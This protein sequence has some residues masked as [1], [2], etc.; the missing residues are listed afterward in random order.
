MKKNTTA[1]QNEKM[2]SLIQQSDIRNVV[3]SFIFGDPSETIET[4]EKTISWW[5][6]HLEYGQLT[7]QPIMVWPGS[8][9]YDDVC[10]S[11][12]IQPLE[13][14]EKGCPLIN[15]TQMTDSAYRNLVLRIQALQDECFKISY[16][17]LLKKN[18]TDNVTL[19]SFICE[20]CSC[21]NENRLILMASRWES[22][23]S[24]GHSYRFN[25]YTYNMNIIREGFAALR[26][27]TAIWGC[28]RQAEVLLDTLGLKNIQEITL[29]DESTTM[30]G[31]TV[32][33]LIINSP[34]ILE[35]EKYQNVVIM[36]RAPNIPRI[37]KLI[38]DHYPH[39]YN[40]M[41]G[42]ELFCYFLS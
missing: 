26:G 20:R 41:D 31:Q 22:C 8:K 29:V 6:E 42:H 18:V 1:I 16:P 23:R 11:G 3:A 5:Q 9:L 2:F 28:G 4:S 19:F 15:V 30:Q 40:I 33:G 17:H 34:S 36:E 37:T 39:I 13:Y 21:Y 10:K 38:N 24:C 7:L 27:R 12:K 32:K 14:I 25:F 35:R